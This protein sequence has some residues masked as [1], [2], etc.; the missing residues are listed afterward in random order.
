M[1][2]STISP[3]GRCLCLD[4]LSRCTTLKRHRSLW[5]GGGRHI[6]FGGQ[7][8]GSDPHLKSHTCI[9]SYQKERRSNNHEAFAIHHVQP[10]YLL[11]SIVEQEQRQLTHNDKIS[12]Y[13]LDPQAGNKCNIGWIGQVVIVSCYTAALPKDKCICCSDPDDN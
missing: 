5:G 6:E 13:R 1:R 12:Q 2:R 11:E 3:H 9:T 10:P 4:V 7:C 8:Y